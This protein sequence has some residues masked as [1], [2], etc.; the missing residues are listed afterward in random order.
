MQNNRESSTG[1]TP[2]PHLPCLLDAGRPIR[3]SAPVSVAMRRWSSRPVISN[4]RVPSG[5]LWVMS[6]PIALV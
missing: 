5:V 6:A 3:G 2:M 4:L 1:A